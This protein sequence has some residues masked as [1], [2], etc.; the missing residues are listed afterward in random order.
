MANK[1][2]SISDTNLSGKR[3]LRRV[4]FNVPM[5][6]GAITSAARIEAA[7][8]TIRYALD[9]GAS[10]VLMSHLGRPDGARNAK[11]SLEPVA[12][13][14]EQLL[15]RPVRFL[16][17]CVGSEVEAACADPAAGSVMLLENLRY[18]PEEESKKVTGEVEAFRKSLTKLAD[19]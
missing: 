14:L 8:P 7:L 15:G 6:D 4:D 5:K 10:V 13:K 9:Q 11:Y 3:V 16:D 2:L 1:K 18:H 17:D 12:K 19:V